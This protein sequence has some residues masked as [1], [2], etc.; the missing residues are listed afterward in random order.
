MTLLERFKEWLRQSG[1]KPF[2]HPDSPEIIDSL[3]PFD[4]VIE[5]PDHPMARILRNGVFT[6]IKDTYEV[7]VGDHYGPYPKGRKGVLDLLVLPVIARH[8]INYSNTT[9]L[10]PI[11][12]A[13]GFFGGLF[14]LTRQLSA[15]ALTIALTPVVASVHIIL[16]IPA[17]IIKNRAEKL[18]VTVMNDSTRLHYVEGYHGLETVNS[19]QLG[20]LLSG[21]KAS[22]ADIKVFNDEYESG[23]AGYS[24][25]SK[26][27]NDPGN[28]HGFKTITFFAAGRAI[29][30]NGLPINMRGGAIERKANEI[31]K[32]AEEAM[33]TLNVGGLNRNA[34]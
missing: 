8:L 1:V 29:N 18:Y 13:A 14:E 9:E 7:L 11:S 26:N 17:Q 30:I 31:Q 27:A 32:E 6:G 15:A 5:D 34:L 20:V 33:Q 10:G 24:F 22:L 21:H 12:I 19:P 2:N 23:R 25:T 28:A 16:F 3:N 4:A